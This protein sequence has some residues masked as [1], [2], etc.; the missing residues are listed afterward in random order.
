MIVL[1][2]DHNT[3]DH[4]ARTLARVIPGVG[5]D[6]GHAFADRIHSTGQALVWQVERGAIT[7]HMG[8]SASETVYLF[9][10]RAN[11][12]DLW[13]DS[14]TVDL[15]A[16]LPGDIF[17]RTLTTLHVGDAFHVLQ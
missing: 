6:Q 9:G 16:G 12:V 11:G 10:S 3:F 7:T 14:G 17:P 5:L 8:Y 1:N 13:I 2:D 4:V 15:L